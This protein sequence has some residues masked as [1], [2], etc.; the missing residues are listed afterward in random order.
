MRLDP[1]DQVVIFAI[2]LVVPLGIVIANDR[3]KPQPTKRE[4]TSALS[5]RQRVL[6]FCMMIVLIAFFTGM[7]VWMKWLQW[8]NWLVFAATLGS[9]ISLLLGVIALRVAWVWLKRDYLHIAKLNSNQEWGVDCP[10]CQRTIPLSMPEDKTSA[11]IE[12]QCLHC[13]SDRQWRAIL[14]VDLSDRLQTGK[15]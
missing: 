9:V 3:T 14:Q 6:S 8:P 5:L 4:E 12:F 2:L 10:R 11:I 7:A 1:F 13:G 15:F